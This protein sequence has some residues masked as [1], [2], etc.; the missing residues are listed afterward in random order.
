M[1]LV[2]VSSRARPQAWTVRPEDTLES[3]GRGLVERRLHWA[4]VVDTSGAV[5][6]VLSAW[7]LLRFAVEGRPGSMPVWQA[8]TYRPVSV[9]PET[10]LAEAS[11][12]MREL[13]MHHLPVLSSD[14][15]LVAVLSSL[16]LLD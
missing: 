14:G 2:T 3:A 9:A 1:D 11:R 10:P 7:D 12:I 4:P 5:L 16:D 13:K 8:C 6:A 15:R